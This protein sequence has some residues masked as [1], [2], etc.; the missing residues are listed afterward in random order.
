MRRGTLTVAGTTLTFTK[1]EVQFG[2]GGLTDPD[3]DFVASSVNGSVTANLEITGPAS[4]P[5][6]VLSSTPELPQ[7]EVL[8]QLLFGSSESQL[9]PFQIASI[10]ATL[11]EFSGAA[12]G[13]SDPLEGVRSG[14]GLDRLSVGGGG[15]GSTPTLQAG[16][17]VAPGIYVGAKQALGSSTP[18]N[19][20]ADPTT[21]ATVQIDLTKRL[22]V[23]GDA[24]SGVGANA[25]GLTY[26]FEY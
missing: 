12:N 23:E 24:G 15:S 5:K 26:Q 8:A 2:G 3:I 21:Q 14:L 25:V 16:R 1:G 7:D 20:A 11:A 10:A 6:I 17:Y 22:K 9:S 19:G 13:L 4:R 18:S